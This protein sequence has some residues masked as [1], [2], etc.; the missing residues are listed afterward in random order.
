MKQ[1]AVDKF[2]AAVIGMDTRLVEIAFA[3]LFVLRG[4]LLLT[5]HDV[6]VL[7]HY[8]SGILRGFHLFGYESTFIGGVMI[9]I[10]VSLLYSVLQ[11]MIQNNHYKSRA[12]WMFAV[13]FMWSINVVGAYYQNLNAPALLLLAWPGFIAM[14]NTLLLLLKGEAVRL[15]CPSIRGTLAVLPSRGEEKRIDLSAKHS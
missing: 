15:G 10:G 13:T 7:N 8:I 2:I 4:F 11:G 6:P 3:G 1:N 14:F 12:L 9:L 5:H